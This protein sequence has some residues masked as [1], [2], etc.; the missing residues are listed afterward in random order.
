MGEIPLLETSNLCK[1]FG[2]VHA[3][4]DVSVTL[5]S[6]MIQCIIGPNG[7]GKTTFF[8]LLTGFLRPDQGNISFQ[9][10]PVT[11]WPPHRRNRAGISRSFQRPQLFPQITVRENV[12]LALQRTGETF[13]PL[14]RPFSPVMEGMVLKSLQ[15]F[16]LAA[17]AQMQAGALSH[18][19]KK[20]LDV[21]MAIASNP[22][23][24]LLDEPT[25]GMT[26][27][28]T[29]EMSQVLKK[30]AASVTMVIIEHDLG[31]V[32]EIADKIIV[33]HRGSV[34]AE[35]CYD[36]IG[37]NRLVQDIYLGGPDPC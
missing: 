36:E 23:L 14:R 9:G 35:G 3:V 6:G 29:E 4:Q 1:S 26:P 13:N 34:V 18:G 19:E 2:G 33:L 11:G 12:F 8:N 32:R 24:L 22:V 7:A 10:N 37:C 15:Q 27:A 16:G 21:A 31:F 25:A 20:R 5:H 28:E 17:L 30:I